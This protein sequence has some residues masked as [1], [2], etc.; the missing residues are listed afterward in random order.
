[1]EQ[2]R[3]NRLVIRSNLTKKALDFPIEIQIQTINACN[4]SCLMCP[5]SQIKKQKIET[6]SEE[7]FNKIIR[8]IIGENSRLRYVDLYLQN[9]PLMDKDIFKKSDCVA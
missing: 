1:M 5:N 6:M 3:Y 8:E 4:G 9:E 2:S 7:L